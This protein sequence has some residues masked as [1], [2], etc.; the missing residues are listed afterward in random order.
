MLI[1][2]FFE[3]TNLHRVFMGSLLHLQDYCQCFYCQ[4]TNSVCDITEAAVYRTEQTLRNRRIRVM[5]TYKLLVSNGNIYS[6]Y[7]KE[8]LHPQ[9]NLCDA[10]FIRF[11]EITLQN[12][13]AHSYLKNTVKAIAILD[14]KAAYASRRNISHTIGGIQTQ[15]AGK[16]PCN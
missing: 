3:W 9:N 4:L 13:T 12:W 2:Q 1:G 15:H 8:S 7:A 11:I 14:K 6:N 5:M 10:I 16:N